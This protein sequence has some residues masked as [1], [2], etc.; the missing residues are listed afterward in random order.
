MV[1]DHPV[2]VDPFSVSPAHERVAVGPEEESSIMGL[3]HARVAV[4]PEEENSRMGLDA[5]HHDVVV[6]GLVGR[7]NG[8]WCPSM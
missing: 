6:A 1:V 5:Q 2:W 4:G 7:A 3:A 8:V